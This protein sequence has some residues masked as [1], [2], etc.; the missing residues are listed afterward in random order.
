M[1]KN[2]IAEYY[3][4]MMKDTLSC[5]I[6]DLHLFSVETILS[7]TCHIYGPFEFRTSL[8]AS[9]LLGSKIKHIFNRKYVGFNE[10]ISYV[11]PMSAQRHKICVG[12]MT[13][14]CP[15]S[16]QCKLTFFY[17][18]LEAS[19]ASYIHRAN[20]CPTLLPQRQRLTTRTTYTPTLG[21]CKHCC[22]PY[23]KNYS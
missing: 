4:W 17:I 13:L 14:I 18:Q 16:F 19:F 9:I 22:N 2:Q 21:Q 20:V 5:P 1:R 11:W 8:G 10:Y 12:L 3:K 15:T 7:W 6:W 23:C